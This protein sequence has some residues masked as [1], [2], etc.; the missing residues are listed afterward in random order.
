MKA[1][2]L[3]QPYEPFVIEDVDLAEPSAGEVLVRIVATGVCHSD[4]HFV[5]G[6]LQHPMP[7]VLGHEGAGVVESVGPGVTYV[8]PG[9][10]VILCFVPTCGSCRYCVAGRPNL[11]ISVRRQHGV[12]RDGTSRLSI[13][14]EPVHPFLMLSTFAERAVVAEEAVVKIREDAPLDK[15]CL[16]SCGVMTGIGA[17]TN[18]AH[19][20]PGCTCVV[21][22]CGG[23][24][25]NVV[26]GCAIAG[27][28]RIIAIDRDVRKLEYAKVF[29]ATDTIDASEG[30][31][32]KRVREIERDLADYAFEAVGLPETIR[33]A[34]DCV[35]RG[36]L[37]VIVGLA[38]DDSEVTLPAQSFITEKGI[39][40]S[41]YGSTRQR[42]DIPRLVDMYM[43]GQIKL[44]ELITRTY[45]LDEINAAF[46]D[47]TSG[48]VARGVITF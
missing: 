35:G 19:I 22:G 20:E 16:I 4:Q 5:D 3:H 34:Y 32:P 39:I 12:M 15:V 26:Q 7:V 1:A 46:E 33:L 14:G 24:G 6:S 44:D 43:N 10:H 30:Q 18:T 21:V 2:V 40:G 27:A 42:L 25:L 48:N 13:D 38:A 28:R 41:Y 29:G 17:V 47:M 36:G 11:C 37:A 8:E 31:V 9:D 45:T 23:V